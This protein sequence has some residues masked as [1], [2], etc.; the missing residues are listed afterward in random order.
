MP[1]C[2]PWPSDLA[3]AAGSLR[4]WLAGTALVLAA[5]AAPAQEI[6]VAAR[7]NGV[8][9]SIFRL[10][11]YFEDYLKE[12]GRNL[13]SI[14]SPG[15]YKRLKRDAL[16][17]LI[18]RELLSQEGVRR[19]I[20]VPGSEVAAA[21]ARAMAGYKTPEAFQRRLREA[22]FSEADFADYVRHDLRARQA[23]GA[24][25]GNAEP[26]G[27]EV[28]RFYREQRERFMLPERVH[29]RH[30]L[31]RVAAGATAEEKAVA[32][33]R[34]LAVAGEIRHGADF[35]QLAERHSEDATRNSGGDLGIFPR[36]KM[37]PA[38]EA[39]AFSLPVGLLS[40]PV[41]TSFGWHLIRV[42][43]HFAPQEMPQEQALALIRR[44][45]A[46]ERRSAGEAR[47]L[48]KLR[49]AARVEVLLAL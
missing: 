20:V 7:V 29:A 47:A 27:D 4:R 42:E 19:G 48:E 14:R 10:E 12:Q 25:A 38:F 45:L 46:A 11:R 28:E 37:L 13:G 44:H 30:I 6:G 17:R 32:H 1:R 23:L 49:Q 39:A 8:E 35:A 41:E 21:R 22:G 33:R 15:A 36:G 26:S 3:G 5:V 9:I 34:L 16:E 31:I 40:E 43:Q 2:A 24:L 18:D